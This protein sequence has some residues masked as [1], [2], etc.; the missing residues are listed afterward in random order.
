M[1]VGMSSERRARCLLG[2]TTTLP[3]HCVDRA[4]HG[5]GAETPSDGGG[6]DG[7]QGC[8]LCADEQSRWPRRD[9]G[10]SCWD[11]R[12]CSC[13]SSAASSFSFSSSSS[14]SSSSLPCPYYYPRPPSRPPL[15]LVLAQVPGT[16]VPPKTLRA[17]RISRC[18]CCPRNR[19]ARIAA[20]GRLVHRASERGEG[21]G[22]DEQSKDSGN[23]RR[24]RGSFFFLKKKKTT[25]SS[26]VLCSSLTVSTRRARRGGCCAVAAGGKP[27]AKVTKRGR[28]ARETV[29]RKRRKRLPPKLTSFAGSSVA[30]SA[31][32]R[33]HAIGWRRITLSA[34]V[35][36]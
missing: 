29:R 4:G 25:W 14:S 32:A 28:E 17:D 19:A 34:G 26:P 22:V 27:V 12:S 3:Q 7:R 1:Y 36:T 35:S 16:L 5:A 13:A 21:R 31:A 6:T 30:E 2:R 20:A 9:V 10:G 11:V 15:L 23:P 33:R 24:Q 8:G 18:C